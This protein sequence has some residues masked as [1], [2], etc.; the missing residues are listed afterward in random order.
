MRALR[1]WGGRVSVVE[2]NE[3]AGRSAPTERRRLTILFC[4]LID[5][6]QLSTT[7]GDLEAAHDAIEAFQVFCV[8]QIEAAGGYVARFGGDGQLAYFGYPTALEDAPQRALHA[9]A[10]ICEARKHLVRPDG[11]PVAVRVGVATGLVVIGNLVSDG[12]KERTVTGE[13]P[14]LASRLQGIAEPNTVVVA[15]STK[16]LAEGLFD[17]TA[18]GLVELK[19]FPT[20]LPAWRLAGPRTLV[21]RYDGG[22]TAS[23]LISRDDELAQV[24]EAWRLAQARGGGVVGIQGEAGIGKSRLL[25]EVRR[26]ICQDETVLWLEGGGASLYDNTPFHV[27]SQIARSL[28]AAFP[29]GEAGPDP[30]DDLFAGDAG[31]EEDDRRDELMGLAAARIRAAAAHR[32][33]A[34]VVED[35]HWADPS[36][37]ELL[38]LVLRDG[39]A[40][41]ILLVYTSRSDTVRWSQAVPQQVVRLGALDGD[42][43]AALARSAGSDR[44]TLAQ[45]TTII[46]RTGG[47]PFYVEELARRI[48]DQPAAAL[49]E[50]LP[51]RLTDL[52]TPRL[53]AAGPAK[54]HAQIAAVLGAQ[55][56]ASLFAAMLAPQD[57]DPAAVL[58]DLQA[59]SIIVRGGG[60]M[61]A[62]R[63]ALI[64]EAA[65]EM[66][67]KRERCE[68]HEQAARLILADPEAETPPQV[69]ARHWTRA[70]RYAEAFEAWRAAAVAG[71]R[72]RALHEAEHAYRQALDALALIQAP[73]KDL[74]E[75]PV[76]AAFNRVLRVTQ[77]YSSPEAEL[78]SQRVT[79]MASRKGDAG[80][81]TREELAKWQGVFTAGDFAGAEA[82]L[83]RVMDLTQDEEGA[84]WRQTLA[85]RSGIQQGF[86]TGDLA[87]GER[88]FQAWEALWDGS[89]RAP[90]DDVLSMGIG[91]LIAQLSGRH[92]TARSRIARAFEIAALYAGPY[93]LAMAIHTQACFHHFA[94]DAASQAVSAERLARV[95]ADSRFEYASHLATGWLAIADLNA[96]RGREA[97]ER[98]TATIKGFDRLGARVSTPFWLGV[99]ARAQ[100]QVGDGQGAEATFR[101]GL[102]CNPQERAFLPEVRLARARLLQAAGRPREAIADLVQVARLSR[103]MGA[104][105]FQFRALTTLAGMSREAKAAARRVA[106]RR[107]AAALSQ[108][109][110]GPV[111]RARYEALVRA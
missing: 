51:P 44:L 90:G 105:Q 75:L 1:A 16:R 60:D 91:G 55:F 104:R 99:Q 27:A 41:R 87:R 68:L 100:W 58:D 37:V 101:G 89:H 14:N 53:E 2:G 6:T 82:L 69:V 73:D 61:C 8:K 34:L 29:A 59:R 22:R 47:V 46:E 66:L 11:S 25:D 5:S 108:L 56:S 76:R 40:A 106:S 17:F 52:L 4:D 95:A 36:S 78:S 94:E 70:G 110:H 35:L 28:A 63:H 67:L 96:G 21:R 18:L 102:A 45:V 72:R 33:V 54:R 81:V 65:Y 39:G 9:A 3:R 50:A 88:D 64:A 7:D 74:I 92:A 71:H 97:L 19:N 79:V 80:R 86:Y 84:A 26:R 23:R 32:P 83:Q 57:G 107:A 43:C 62:F 31:G 38:D 42:G 30:F 48:A 109:D 98:V 10:A 103:R 49:D 93:D 20:P 12:A 111:D 85:L 77:G 13:A 15:D 24:L